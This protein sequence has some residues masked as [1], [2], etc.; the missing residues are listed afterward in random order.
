MTNQ[1]LTGKYLSTSTVG[2]EVVR[3]FIPNPLPPTPPLEMTPDLQEDITQAYL[4][5]GR[6]DSITKFLPDSLLFLYSYIRK[7]AVLSSQIE[8]TQSSLSDLL[9]FELH[10]APGVPLDDVTEVSCYVEAL[11]HGLKRIRS[12]FPLSN[13]LIR[14]MHEILLGKGRGAEKKPGDFRTSQNWLGGTRPGNAKYVPPPAE[15]V[16]PC[17]SDLEKFLHNDP[18]KTPTLLKAALAHVQFETIHPFLDGNGREGRL[19]I[20][21]L[22]CAENLL[23]E[24]LLYL[25]LFFKEHRS[26]YYDHLQS[27]RTEGNW[28]G[29]VA[30][31]AEAVRTTADG[32]VKTA[33]QI[34]TL[35]VKDRAKIQSLKRGAGS[36]LRI[37]EEM[38]KRPLITIKFLH[39]RTKINIPTITAALDRLGDLGI[40][41]EITGHRRNRVFVYQKYLKFL[42]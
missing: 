41:K 39:Q 10:E 30:F 11:V 18:V 27:V 13:R 17:M 40:A 16:T 24:P 1:S 21:I 6:L 12:G 35:T 32:A 15:Y 19:L 3:S 25:S 34:L 29:W 38:V 22:F 4:S 26:Q 23:E 9:L 28:L 36:T 33:Q 14:E 7:E 2:G 20:P 5:L 37:H 42:A 31:F 8:G